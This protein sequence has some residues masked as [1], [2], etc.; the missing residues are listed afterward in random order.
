VLDELFARDTLEVVEE[1]IETGVF[2]PRAVEA[3][4][5]ASRKGGALSHRGQRLPLELEKTEP[6]LVLPRPTANAPTRAAEPPAC[7][8]TRVSLFAI[9]LGVLAFFGGWRATGGATWLD[10]ATLGEQGDHVLARASGF[11]AQNL[12]AA[13]PPAR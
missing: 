1:D 11:I 5:R 7:P 6:A 13:P 3:H 4:V 12:R 2:D 9:L 8:G 10:Q